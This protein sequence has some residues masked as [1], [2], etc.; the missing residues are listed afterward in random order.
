MN[1]RSVSGSSARH[2]AGAANASGR[3][4][5]TRGAPG[6]IDLRGLPHRLAPLLAQ[7]RWRL[8]AA[9]LALARAD[10]ELAKIDDALA[11]QQDLLDRESQQAVAARA[12]AVLDP[13]GLHRQVLWCGRLRRQ[14]MEMVRSRQDQ[15]DRQAQLREACRQWMRQVD[16]LETH[17]G[18]EIRV[19]VLAGQRLHAA[20]ADRDW[21]AR[22]HV[23]A[24]AGNPPETVE[25]RPVVPAA[26]RTMEA[27][28]NVEAAVEA[29]QAVQAAPAKTALEAAAA[30]SAKTGAAA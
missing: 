27:E 30:T 2:A 1:G 16:L 4:Q 17:R 21:I 15:L 8:D 29:V 20:E 11:A 13:H 7:A 9:E 19:H 3:R 6:G 24:V 26:G 14:Q 23:G 25:A 28:M 10:H 18:R 5:E 22:C 12:S